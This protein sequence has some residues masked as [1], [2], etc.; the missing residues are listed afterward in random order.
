VLKCISVP[1]ADGKNIEPAQ[2][3]SNNIIYIYVWYNSPEDYISTLLCHRC[4]FSE[5]VSTR[6]HYMYYAFIW[7]LPNITYYYYIKQTVS[8]L[9]VTAYWNARERYPIT[10][11]VLAM[12]IS[13]DI[14]FCDAIVESPLN[15]L[16]S[17]SNEL[18]I[19]VFPN[20]VLCILLFRSDAR[21][22]C[23]C[24]RHHRLFTAGGIQTKWTAS[25]VKCG[26]RWH[27]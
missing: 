23:V 5:H 14:L 22:L 15:R 25:N 12:S 20:T 18:S 17:L 7:L 6:V 4:D 9:D 24:T 21:V 3:Y 8:G 19:V 16:Y 27:D 1:R 2:W 11:N 26:T 13:I 10:L